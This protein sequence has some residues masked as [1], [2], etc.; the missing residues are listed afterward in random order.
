MVSA[1][2]LSFNYLITASAVVA[3][4]SF[5]FNWSGNTLHPTLT[6]DQVY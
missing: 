4:Y 6:K 3:N 2:Y 1:A 5:S